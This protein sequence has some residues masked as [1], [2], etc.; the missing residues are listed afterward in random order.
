MKVNTSKRL[1]MLAVAEVPFDVKKNSCTK[2]LR[3]ISH[4]GR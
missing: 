1:P 4:P 2:E 3:I